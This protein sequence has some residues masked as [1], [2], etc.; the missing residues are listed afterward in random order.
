MQPLDKSESA[1]DCCLRAAISFFKDNLKKKSLCLSPSGQTKSSDFLTFGCS[2]PAPEYCPLL[3]LFSSS[4][5]S[6]PIIYSVLS[7]GSPKTLPQDTAPPPCASPQCNA[8]IKLQHSHSTV[9]FCFF[10]FFV[11]RSLTQACQNHT[12]T[13]SYTHT[14]SEVSEMQSLIMCV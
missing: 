5:P 14:A 12:L 4:A 13:A 6:L 3:F 11:E 1:P 7:D 10:F 2:P 9:V 8:V